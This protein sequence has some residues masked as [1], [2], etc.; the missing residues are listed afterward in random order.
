MIKFTRHAMERIS[1]RNI[2]I[3]DVINCL[4]SPDKVLTDK[5]GN[6]I[7]QKKK[8]NYLLRV[9]FRKNNDEILVITAYITSKLKKYEGSKLT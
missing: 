6:K 5:F 4:I 9:I 8:D 1:E 3:D 7:A 2:K